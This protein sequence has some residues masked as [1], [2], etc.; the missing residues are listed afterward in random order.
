M[1]ENLGLALTDFW[2]LTKTRMNSQNFNTKLSQNFTPISGLVDRASAAGT[3]DLGSTPGRV[4]PKSIKHGIHSL[5]AWR[6]T[7]KETV[8]SLHRVW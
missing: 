3:V 2:K 8:W 4:K 1:Y 7:I 5:P 6:S